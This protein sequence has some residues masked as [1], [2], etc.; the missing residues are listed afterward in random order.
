MFA[1]CLGADGSYLKS[2]RGYFVEGGGWQFGESGTDAGESC[3]L[4]AAGEGLSL[5]AVFECWFEN[6]FVPELVRRRGLLDYG[7]L[8]VLVVED[9]PAHSAVRLL[10]LCR[11]NDVR[12]LHWPVSNL[13]ELQPLE[14]SVF[15][16]CQEFDRP[17]ESDGGE[18]RWVETPR[19]CCLVV[20]FCGDDGERC[21]DVPAVGHRCE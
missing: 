2:D 4:E 15:E 3:R 20:H 8:A 10:E 6:I 21:V 7:G 11:V 12:L 5:T 13:N 17:S 1:A 18:E 14:T 9:C 19:R 16:V